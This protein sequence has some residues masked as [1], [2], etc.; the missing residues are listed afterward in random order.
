MRNLRLVIA[1]DGRA[2]SGWQIQKNVRSVQ[3]TIEE[4]LARLT[5]QPCR[6]RA[7]GRTDAGVHAAGQMANFRSETSLD[8]QRLH[9]GLNA[10]L[11]DDI[12]IV[13]V[14]EVDA[15]FDSRRANGGKHYR[16]RIF[17]RREPSI[18]HQRNSWHFWGQ[19]DLHAMARAGQRLVG[20]HD[21]AAFRAADCDRETTE[22]TI[23]RCTISSAP[24]LIAIDVT[25]TA[26]LKNMVRIIT[27]TLVD[28]GRGKLPETIIDEM[29]R[30]GER[31]LGGPT[32]PAHG[33]T[34]MRVFPQA[35]GLERGFVWDGEDAP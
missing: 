9:R 4:V 7:S 20:R 10:L 18:E 22:R 15:A 25:G 27:G 30:T 17:N 33:L 19:L 2:Y 26:F 8:C 11:P 21:F 24:P 32:A 13:Q 28:I 16:Y 34:L 29:L 1:Y 3:G 14:D 31:T 35:A 6:L 23:Y 5:G 12:S